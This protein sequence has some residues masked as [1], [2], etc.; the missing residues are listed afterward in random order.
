MT[1]VSSPLKMDECGS[2][3]ICLPDSKNKT[4][5]DSTDPHRK[6]YL[7][8]RGVLGNLAL[9]ALAKSGAFG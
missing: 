9:R 1:S 2:P 6:K 5:A 7:K 8:I 4:A 3:Y